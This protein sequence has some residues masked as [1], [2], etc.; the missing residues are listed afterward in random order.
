MWPAIFL[1]PAGLLMF[2]FSIANHELKHS[3]I[4]ATVG[5]AVT[6]T[7]INF[8]RPGTYICSRLTLY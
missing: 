3:Y 5:M 8:S 1:L 7:R 4:G 2:G 6:C